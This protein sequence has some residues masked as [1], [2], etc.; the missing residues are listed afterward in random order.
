M[1]TAR[2]FM[3][4]VYSVAY[5][6][7]VYAC[8]TAA[9]DAQLRSAAALFIAAVMMLVGIGREARHGVQL[10]QVANAYRH[11]TPTKLGAL[12]EVECRTALPPQCRCALWWQTLGDRHD[13]QCP[14][15]TSKEPR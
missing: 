12:A 7:T 13:E 14:A 4:T 6:I 1:T 3:F 2:A 9:E 5:C 10:V 11:G 15:L 8:W